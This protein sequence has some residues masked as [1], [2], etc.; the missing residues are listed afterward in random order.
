[1]QIVSRASAIEKGSLVYYS[2]KP[3]KHGHLS[4]RYVSTGHCLE[5]CKQRHKENAD[6]LNAKSREW[7]ISNKERAKEWRKAH[8]KSN[9]AAY[10][11]KCN[12]RRAAKLQATPSWSSREDFKNMKA[13]YEMAARLSSCLKVPHDVDHIIP[14][15]SPFVCGLNVPWNLQAIP[16]SMNK[17]KGNRLPQ[18]TI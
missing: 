4:E 7:Y 6:L 5:C 16:A 18:T 12:R 9:R 3:C 8:A 13:V 14:L 15:N 2:G 10:L 11:E 17:S 1:M